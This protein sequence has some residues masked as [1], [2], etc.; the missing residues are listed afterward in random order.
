MRFLIIMVLQVD[1]I[2]MILQVDDNVSKVRSLDLSRTS[3]GP[4]RP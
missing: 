3:K 4:G 1:D 2:I